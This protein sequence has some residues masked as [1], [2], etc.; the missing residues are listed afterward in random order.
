A[1]AR[2]HLL[3]VPVCE[4]DES[5]A[6]GD[7][8][9]VPI[10]ALAREDFAQLLA[11]VL[12]GRAAPELAQE[13]YDESRGLPGRT[14]REARQRIASGT[15]TWTPSG[16]DTTWRQRLRTTIFPALASI[17]FLLLGLTAGEGMV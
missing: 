1:A 8:A 14:C 4:M 5:D 12:Q 15:L 10:P 2:Q 3:L 9:V 17:P 7:E 13:L 16:V 11:L 6:I